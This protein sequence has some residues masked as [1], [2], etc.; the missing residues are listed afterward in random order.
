MKHRLSISTQM[1]IIFCAEKILV[2]RFGSTVTG[3]WVDLFFQQH[4]SACCLRSIVTKVIPAKSAFWKA[5]G[6]HSTQNQFFLLAFVPWTESA[7]ITPAQHRHLC[8]QQSPFKCATKSAALLWLM[9]KQ[10]NSDVVSQRRRHLNPGLCG[11]VHTCRSAYLV[12]VNWPQ[13]RM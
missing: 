13:V 5:A 7:T 2:S 11:L 3:T 10:S 8:G 4:T 9:E 6:N 1:I 12:I